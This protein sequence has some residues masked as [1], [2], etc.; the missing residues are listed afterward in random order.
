MTTLK[1]TTLQIFTEDFDGN[2][3]SIGRRGGNPWIF[4]YTSSG[5]GNNAEALFSSEHFHLFICFKYNTITSG[6]NMTKSI[7]KN[8]HG[9]WNG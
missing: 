8:F 2:S 7:G 3:D 5:K 4:F 9:T 6:N 1:Q